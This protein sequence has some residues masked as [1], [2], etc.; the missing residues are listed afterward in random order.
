MQ[1]TLLRGSWGPW[2]LMLWCVMLGGHLYSIRVMPRTPCLSCLISLH[3]HPYHPPTLAKSQTLWLKK[4]AWQSVTH[5]LCYN[6]ITL[7]LALDNWQN[8]LQLQLWQLPCWIFTQ[9]SL[10]LLKVFQAVKHDIYMTMI[11]P[12]GTWP[13]TSVWREKV[14]FKNMNIWN[15]RLFSWSSSTWIQT[16]QNIYL[17]QLSQILQTCLVW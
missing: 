3:C 13:K 14:T 4:Y 9:F 1:W 17:H 11:W 2:G 7:L 12:E 6:N 8:L 15:I 5:R 16:L 10:G